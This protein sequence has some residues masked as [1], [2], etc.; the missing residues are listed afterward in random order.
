MGKIAA[1]LM[2]A[3]LGSHTYHSEYVVTMRLELGERGSV[4]DLTSTSGAG[5]GE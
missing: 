5:A 3:R 2:L 1:E 4:A